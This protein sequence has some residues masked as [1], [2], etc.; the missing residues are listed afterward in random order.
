MST[1]S[2]CQSWHELVAK[3][4]TQQAIDVDEEPSLCELGK[5][6]LDFKPLV[7]FILLSDPH[8]LELLVGA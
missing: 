7:R 8:F 6:D 2:L 1:K 3:R 5:G 4:T